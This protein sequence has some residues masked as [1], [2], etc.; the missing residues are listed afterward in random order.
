MIEILFIFLAQDP[1]CRGPKPGLCQRSNGASDADW[2]T[3]TSIV[4]PWWVDLKMLD[5]SL[6]MAHPRFIYI[7]QWE[8]VWSTIKHDQSCA[9][10]ASSW[11]KPYGWSSFPGPWQRAKQRIEGDLGPQCSSSQVMF[12]R[13]LVS[14]GDHC[15]RVAAGRFQLA[16]EVD[17]GQQRPILE[18]SSLPIST[19]GR[20]YLSWKEFNIGI[21]CATVTG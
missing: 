19:S 1:D 18:Q 20:I 2:M 16:A 21:K 10:G 14:H 3:K 15:G 7:C 11:T 5:L 4:K 8:R 9:V 6:K 12:Q 13:N 17:F